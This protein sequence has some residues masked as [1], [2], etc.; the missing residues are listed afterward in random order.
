MS[1]VQESFRAL[2]IPS[3]LSWKQ[4]LRPHSDIE[5]G[6]SLIFGPCLVNNTHHGLTVCAPWTMLGPLGQFSTFLK[7]TQ[8]V[9][10]LQMGKRRPCVLNKLLTHLWDTNPIICLQKEGLSSFSP[11][12]IKVEL[13]NPCLLSHCFSC[14]PLVEKYFR[15][16]CLPF[17][18]QTI[19]Q[20]PGATMED[21]DYTADTSVR[22]PVRRRTDRVFLVAALVSQSS[23]HPTL[24]SL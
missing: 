22:L 5:I 7:I 3:V 23:C 15:L 6:E 24:S 20:G 16:L 11:L 2:R 9:S 8:R 13:L 17:Q 14:L 10:H 1:V 21:P 4:V 19:L 12:T 18:F